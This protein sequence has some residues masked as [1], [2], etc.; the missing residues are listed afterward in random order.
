M[1]RKTWGMPRR[2]RRGGYQIRIKNVL[3]MIWMA[4]SAQTESKTKS[5]EKR[6]FS[7]PAGETK[8]RKEAMNMRLK[9]WTCQKVREWGKGTGHMEDISSNMSCRHVD[10]AKPNRDRDSAA[11]VGE[12]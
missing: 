2:W 1:R 6:G 8:A 10:T 4:A 5:K 11:G 9:G 7:E 3:L 12:G